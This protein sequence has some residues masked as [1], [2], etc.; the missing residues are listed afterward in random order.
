MYIQRNNILSKKNP[1]Q[2][3]IFYDF[4]RNN[5]TKKNIIQQGKQLKYKTCNSRQANILK[6]D[7]ENKKLTH[8]KKMENENHE[9]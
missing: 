8:W 2:Y 4:K 1:Q 6:S 9:N 7:L 3:S 5:I